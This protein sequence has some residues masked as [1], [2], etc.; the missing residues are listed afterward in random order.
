MG[1]FSQLL[2]FVHIFAGFM[3]LKLSLHLSIYT[4]WV[5]SAF[6]HFGKRTSNSHLVVVGYVKVHTVLDSKFT[7]RISHLWISHSSLVIWKD[8]T[9]KTDEVGTNTNTFKVWMQGW[10]IEIWSQKMCWYKKMGMQNS[11]ILICHFS[12]LPYHRCEKE[13]CLYT[14][15]FCHLFA[16]FKCWKFGACS[17]KIKH[18]HTSI[19]AWFTKLR[20]GRMWLQ[21][22]TPVKQKG[23]CRK[24]KDVPIPVFFAEPSVHSNSFVGTEEYIAPVC[25]LTIIDLP[26]T[27]LLILVLLALSSVQE[28]H[29]IFILILFP[30]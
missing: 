9:L 30:W 4:A 12:H 29:W 22:I 23:R 1:W 28:I 5:S 27:R 18:K 8:K 24:Q 7:C 2:K 16:K 10:C 6:N 11:L 26:T 3:Q 15:K 17:S 20:F 14:T 13:S 21:L 25:S 19:L